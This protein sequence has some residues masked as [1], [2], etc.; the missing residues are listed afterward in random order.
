M[1]T[2]T[3]TYPVFGQLY[4]RNYFMA[5]EVLR[6]ILALGPA[7]AVP[8]LLKIADTTLADY[9]AG[10]LNSTDW[11]A[12]YYF[13]HALN[14]L[15]ELHAPQALDVYR[16][17]LH[18]DA[19]GTDFWFG[20][21]LYEEVP[22][23]LARA[24]ET[25]LPELLALLE[26]PAMLLMHRLVVAEAISRLV[27]EQPELR[28]AIVAFMQQHL[29]R[30]IIHPDQAHPLFP[31]DAGSYS[32]ALEDYLGDLLA[33]LQEA[34]LTELEPEMRELHRL[35]LMDEGMA[36]GEDGIDFEQNRQLQPL[37][38]IFARYQHL[39]DDPD[40]YSPF[41]PDAA[42]IAV[43]R[44]EA[45]ARLARLRA[46]YYTRPQPPQPR[47]VAPKVGRNDSCPCGSGQKYK[48]CH[49]A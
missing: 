4:T 20:D 39:R 19:E 35:N 36:G 46:E 24:A 15:D 31:A 9:E 37:P 12:V 29:G 30:I 26:A 17:L 13:Q 33:D 2:P 18:L 42:A 6:E 22:T 43:R 3:F 5:D 40:N 45:E 27:R 14:L 47:T 8:E 28:P 11:W 44:T 49:G 1:T 41:H 16:R 10:E 34:G 7:T 32:Y 21:D 23:M 25:R 48:K 38:D